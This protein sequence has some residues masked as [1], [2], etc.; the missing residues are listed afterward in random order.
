MLHSRDITTDL[1]RRA[2]TNPESEVLVLPGRSISFAELDDLTWRAAAYFHECGVRS[3]HVVA[4]LLKDDLQVAVASL[5]LVRLGATVAK[6]AS[7]STP[8][9]LQAQLRQARADFVVGKDQIPA[10]TLSTI[11][12]GEAALA[13][14]G[15]RP[16]PASEVD[17]P[18]FLLFGSGS[19][20]E[21]KVMALTAQNIFAFCRIGV[22]EPLYQS[23][24]R[25]LMLFG[26]EFAVPMIR[27]LVLIHTGGT[28]ILTNNKRLDM[29][30]YC[31]DTNATMIQGVAVHFEQILSSIGSMNER[32]F[33]AIR[34]VRVGGSTV[35][36]ELRERIRLHIAPVV[37]VAYAANECGVISELLDDGSQAIAM[38]SVGRPIEG[39]RVQIV[40]PTGDVLGPGQ[41]GM[42]RVK[43]PCL[44]PGYFDDPDATHLRFRDGWFET[45]D[46]GSFTSDGE[47]IFH[48]RADAM[49]ICN[50][51]NIY[52]A[53]I[54][55]C[56]RRLEDVND[57]H[58]FPLLHK[59]HQDIPACVL[60]LKQGSQ[61]T[62]EEIMHFSRQHLGFK[63][64]TL[65][66][67]VE[68]LPRTPGGKLRRAEL[69][70]LVKTGIQER[71]KTAPTLPT[72]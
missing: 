29:V 63:A 24:A 36:R 60:T 42:I 34:A 10:I 45:G 56:L 40:S 55:N 53:E 50:G 62:E 64:P 16:P 8:T 9:Q 30:R 59:V 6:L 69:L 39:I 44:I 47:L 17:A 58:V 4:T 21:P 49:M 11:V 31:R 41:I 51:I 3:G 66:L 33:P 54:E 70:K 26:L 23:N 14:A 38:G 48:G 19:T 18:V 5:G 61:L 32:L 68:T 20:G 57:V 52:P 27:L 2:L 22:S 71:Q 35:S 25:V 37:S 28:L 7:S 43:T 13:R 15:K 12:F 72:P 1:A 46:L 65:L 67:I